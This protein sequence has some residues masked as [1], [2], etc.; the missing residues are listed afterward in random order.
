M[1][2]RCR[3]DDGGVVNVSDVDRSDLQAL[4]FP[5]PHQSFEDHKMT[6]LSEQIATYGYRVD[7]E[8][9]AVEILRKLRLIKSARH[10]LQRQSDQTHGLRFRDP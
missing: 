10:E 8:L 2:V 3:R 9:V 5:N 4:T 7:P 6:E 1:F